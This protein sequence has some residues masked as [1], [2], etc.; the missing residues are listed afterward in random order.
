MKHLLKK[1]KEDTISSD[2]T[3]C[4]VRLFAASHQFAKEF[5]LDPETIAALRN[6]CIE[7]LEC[8]SEKSSPLNVQNS[9][10]CCTLVCLMLWE[11]S[12]MN[13]SNFYRHCT[14]Q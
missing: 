10:D 2:Y 7:S 12:L 8:H 5:E 13:F 3:R 11:C 9:L 6:F 4:F 14:C 1:L